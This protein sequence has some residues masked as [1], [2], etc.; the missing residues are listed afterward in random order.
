MKDLETLLSAYVDGELD[1]AGAA[2]V[3]TLLATDAQARRMVEMYRETG[4]LL[5]AAL[6]E[7]FFAEGAHELLDRPRLGRERAAWPVAWAIAACILACVI[8][9]GGGTVWGSWSNAPREALIDELAEYHAV[10]S[11]ET[12]HLVEVPAT[13]SEH[14]RA[15]LGHRIERRLDIPD[16]TAAGLHFAGGRLLVVDGRPAANLVYTRD[17]GA[18]V[19]LCVL[20]NEAPAEDMHIERRGNLRIAIWQDG[21]YAYFVIGDLDAGMARGIA[22]R[23]AEQI[24]S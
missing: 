20:Q 13:Q 2:E 12:V 14:L 7:P 3:E 15:W 8:G 21:H 19:S 17:R 10:Y 24:R 1:A 22:E 6:A 4:A 9:F 16:L 18:P 5:R 23:A 11:R